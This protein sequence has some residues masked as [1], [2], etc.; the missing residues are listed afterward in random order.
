MENN[1]KSSSGCCPPFDPGPW[2]DK[3]HIWQDK[4]FIKDRVRC[5]LNIP[6]NFGQVITRLIG[7]VEKTGG[8]IPDNICLSDH[9][10]KWSMDIYL[11][12]DKEIPG[13]NN[14]RFSGK[15]LTKVYEGPYKNTGTWCNDFKK[16]VAAKGLDI[17]KWYMWYT[18]CPKCAKFYGKN[19][20][21]VV[22]KTD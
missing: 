9:T 18:T 8:K 14:V 15:F 3:E 1:T 6:L 13:A 20:V 7:L 19:Y 21:V 22:S 12:V 17:K 10:S 2:E 5:F 4:L 11:A 16:Y